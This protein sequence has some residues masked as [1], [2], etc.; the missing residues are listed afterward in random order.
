MINRDLTK[1]EK[2]LL[3]I[4]VLG[5]VALCYYWLVF[6]PVSNQV[7]QY[8]S[9]IGEIETQISINEQLVAK[10]NNWEKAL[11]ESR[12]SDSITVIPE[13]DNSTNLMLDLYA[14]LEQADSYSLEFNSV[15][16]LDGADY[17]VARPISISYY[18]ANY[19]QSRAIIDSLSNCHYINQISD[20]VI[21]NEEGKTLT[22]LYI[23][24][25]EVLD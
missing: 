2:I 8:K 11:E 17:L 14:V 13:Y 3:L 24:F 7:E 6:V 10:V 12:K 20:V 5:I 19:S 4:L 15:E 22:Q 16:N 18:T 21:T 1:R 25:Y 23:T 9:D